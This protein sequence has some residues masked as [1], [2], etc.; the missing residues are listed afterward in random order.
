MFL[1]FPD[2]EYGGSEKDGKQQGGEE[3]DVEG[4]Q[5]A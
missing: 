1:A 3:A 5:K 2:K 4:R